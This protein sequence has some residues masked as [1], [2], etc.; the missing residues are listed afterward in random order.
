MPSDTSTYIAVGAIVAIVIIVLLIVVV[1]YQGNKIKDLSRPKFGFLGKP[2]YAFFAIVVSIG[3]T[4]LLYYGLNQPTTITSTNAAEEITLS[5]RAEPTENDPHIYNFNFTPIINGIAW[6]A[7]PTN[8]F[9]V[10]WTISNGSTVI[11]EAEFQLNQTNIGGLTKTLK[12]GPV[13]VKVT[14]FFQGKNYTYQKNF[15]VP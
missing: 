1:V 9:D 8:K 2:L 11:T 5:V 3:G 7:D 15:D 6:G 10:Y 12:S 13:T 14:A 4:G